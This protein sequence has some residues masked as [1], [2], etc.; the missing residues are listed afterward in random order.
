[1]SA[2]TSASGSHA[3]TAG[4]SPLAIL[5]AVVLA[6]TIVRLAAGALIPLTEDEAYYRLW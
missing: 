2:P 3:E 1:M 5:A 4:L 6:A